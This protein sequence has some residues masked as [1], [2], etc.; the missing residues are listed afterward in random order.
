MKDLI[1]I[2][3]GGHGKVVAETAEAVGRWRDIRF[4]DDRFPGLQS[5]SDW[6][7]EGTAR[8]WRN[9]DVSFVDLLVA[10]GDCVTRCVISKEIRGAGFNMPVLVHPAAWVSPR[11]TVGSGTVVFAG[12]MINVDA[13]LGRSVIVN[14]GATVDHDCVIEDGAH[15]C[16]GAHL[17]AN[18]R[19]GEVSWIGI[20]ASIR[21]N[22]NIGSGVTV[23][24]G[25]AVVTDV[26]DGMTVMGVPARR[27]L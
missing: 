24:S 23:G 26:P 18:V 21:Q 20:G 2:G 14:T 5:A 6:K 7:V 4:M 25:A 27:L 10:V 12:G 19:V 11:A 1:V 22:L 13:Q 8:A 16:P 15:I 17:A 3:A 9:F